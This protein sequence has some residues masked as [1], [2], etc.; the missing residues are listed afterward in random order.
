MFY[1]VFYISLLALSITY[2]INN[3]YKCYNINNKMIVLDRK[4]T[5]NVKFNN[6][7]W[8]LSNNYDIN[9]LNSYFDSLINFGVYDKDDVINNIIKYIGKD[10]NIDKFNKTYVKHVLDRIFLIP[11]TI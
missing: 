10:Y 8:G 5:I 3:L 7:D 4:L 1:D 6:K 11:T 9:N 2:F